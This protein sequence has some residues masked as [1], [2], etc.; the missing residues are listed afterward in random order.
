MK[1]LI[2]FIDNIIYE[3]KILENIS[4]IISDDII[5]ESFKSKLLLQLAKKINTAE[6]N[7]NNREKKYAERMDKEYPTY[8]HKPKYVNFASIF[9]PKVEKHKYGN[10]KGG[11]QG[12]KW[13]E[14]EDSDFDVYED[15]TDKKLIKLIKSTYGK[16]DAMADF[17]I[18]DKNDNILIFIKAYGKDKTADGVFYFNVNGVQEFTKTKYSY[19]SRSLKTDEVIS[20]LQDMKNDDVKVYVLNITPDMIKTYKDL[21]DKRANDKKGVINYDKASLDEMLKQ[22]RARYKTLADEVR[23]KKLQGNPLDVLKEIEDINMKSIALYKKIINNTDFIDKYYSIGDLMSNISRAY[24]SFYRVIKE[25]R[26]ADRSD[27]K[28]PEGRKYNFNRDNATRELSDVND[29]LKRIKNEIERI[30]NELK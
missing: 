26:E 17:I 13:S 21:Y 30:E 18:T 19:Q 27:E 22:Q 20:M 11:I 23:T 9:G 10:D 3:N 12:L 15:P 28:Y 2:S 16:D 6:A 5:N 8:K 14:I 24:D 7:N 29:Y 25:L 1:S 4:Y